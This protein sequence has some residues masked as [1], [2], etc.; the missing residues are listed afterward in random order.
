MNQKYLVEQSEELQLATQ[1]ENGK[2]TDIHG[3]QLL[4]EQLAC[5]GYSD[6]DHILTALARLAPAAIP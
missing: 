6:R 5:K 1:C 4:K 2:A 3:H